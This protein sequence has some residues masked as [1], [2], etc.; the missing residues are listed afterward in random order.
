[1]STARRSA[2]TA[3]GR[4]VA[5]DEGSPFDL[6]EELVAVDVGI[7]GGAASAEEAAV[8][9]V[10]D[11]PLELD[12]VNWARVSEGRAAVRTLLSDAR[13][14][15]SV[16]ENGDSRRYELLVVGTTVGTLDFLRRWPLLTT[17]SPAPNAEKRQRS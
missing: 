2:G 14:D 17:P 3:L 6:K 15:L 11:E 13:R 16:V 7:D 8:H 10:D 12:D 4:L 1:M 9:V 5:P